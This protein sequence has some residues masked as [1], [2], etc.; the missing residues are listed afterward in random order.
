[1]IKK[2]IDAVTEDTKAEETVEKAISEVL[3]A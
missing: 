2:K 1:M 3:Q